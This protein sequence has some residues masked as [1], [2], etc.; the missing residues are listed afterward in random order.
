MVL[1]GL[2]LEMTIRQLEAAGFYQVL[3]PFILI[4]TIIFAVLQKVRLFGANA[5]NINVVIAIL[6]AFFTIRAG[7]VVLLIN[8]FLPKVSAIVLVIMMLLLVLGI[9]G[10]SGDTW[11][12]WPF[13]AAVLL[14]IV[15]V[16]WSVFSS[17]PGLGNLP[18]WIRLS[19]T[20]KGILL[21]VGIML[22]VV[23]MF[24]EDKPAEGWGSMLKKEFGPQAFGRK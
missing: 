11:T 23:S 13:F 8:Q 7:A 21:L 19:S 5:K 16:G 22:I 17:I 18:T 3:L 14:S 24:K 6:I 9:F 15:A 4:F 2:N 1:E 10:I 12:G 20:D